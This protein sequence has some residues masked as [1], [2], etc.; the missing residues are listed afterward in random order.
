LPIGGA[1]TDIGEI[2]DIAVLATVGPYPVIVSNILGSYM[3]AHLTRTRDPLRIV[4]NINQLNTA[5]LT[6]YF[7]LLAFAGDESLSITVGSLVVILLAWLAYI[8]ISTSLVSCAVAL[9]TGANVIS[10]WKGNY[11]HH[12]LVS[13]GAVPLALIM[14]VLF[15][16]YG[17]F[18]VLLVA[19]PLVALN[20]LSRFWI[21]Q[22][23]QQA[24]MGRD[25][26]L[27]EMGKASASVL[28]EISKPLSRIVMASDFALSGGMPLDEALKQILAD[29]HDAHDLSDKLL[30]AMRFELNRSDCSA[31]QIVDQLAEAA[32]HEGIP[33]DI[34]RGPEL[35]RLHGLWDKHLVVAALKNLLRNAWESQEMQGRAPMLHAAA[36]ESTGQG[37]D[38]AGVVLRFA[39]TDSGQ[40]IPLESESDLFEALFS[41]KPTGSGIG[42]FLANQVA[43]AHGGRLRA[44]NADQGGA[45]FMLELPLERD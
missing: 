13:T 44:R 30:G 20:F 17:A 22:A 10:V 33:L 8:S 15:N 7:I 19:L 32:A 14:A 34:S 41:T 28:H 1:V 6:S 29:A 12:A 43:L 3:R 11:L 4:F 25:R 21:D 16:Q 31:A 39:V 5:A 26:Q 23:R 37:A 2:V 45:E 35:N 18:P 42:L 40:G 27:T 24:R 36:T 9:S 38:E